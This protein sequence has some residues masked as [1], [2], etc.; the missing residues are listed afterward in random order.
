MDKQSNLKKHSNTDSTQPTAETLSDLEAI[1]HRLWCRAALHGNLS[2]RTVDY[3]E[4]ET[5]RAILAWVERTNHK[6]GE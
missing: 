4:M 5:K 1:I 6:E 2:G 3:E